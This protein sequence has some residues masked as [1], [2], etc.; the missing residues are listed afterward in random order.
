MK[1]LNVAADPDLFAPMRSGWIYAFGL[2]QPRWNIAR[3]LNSDWSQA[4]MLAKRR[5]QAAI[6]RFGKIIARHLE[7]AL[8]A[9]ERYVITY[10]PA[11]EDHE[12]HLFPDLNRCATEV[13][14]RAIY[15]HM[16]THGNVRMASVLLQVKPKPKKQHQ[17]ASD[18]ERADNVRGIYAATHVSLMA[19]KIVILVDDV[20]TSGATMRECAEVLRS[21][22]ARSVIGI[23]LAKTDRIKL[24][25]FATDQGNDHMKGQAA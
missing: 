3:H 18:R 4:V 5:S 21:A 6:E 7:T 9:A 23:A 25:V 20:L 22:G 2:Y 11:E 17:C 8:L 12:L 16:A 13:L 10:V 24:P 1:T 15:A 14:A 19:G